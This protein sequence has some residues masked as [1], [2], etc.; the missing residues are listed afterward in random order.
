MTNETS[1][2]LIPAIPISSI[3]II[4]NAPIEEIGKKNKIAAF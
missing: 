2:Y 1:P 3:L 4:H